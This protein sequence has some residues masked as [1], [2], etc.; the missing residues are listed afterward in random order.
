MGECVKA[1]FR[2]TMQC[3]ALVWGLLAFAATP[4]ESTRTAAPALADLTPVVRI[5]EIRRTSGPTRW[6]FR[7]REGG[8]EALS[9][10]GTSP[11]A[12]VPDAGTVADYKELEGS[13][14]QTA[15][16]V[17]MS[18]EE[19]GKKDNFYALMHDVERRFGH[20]YG[21]ARFTFPAVPAQNPWGRTQGQ[22]ESVDTSSFLLSQ[23]TSISELSGLLGAEDVTQRRAAAKALALI[24]AAESIPPLMKALA[25]TDALVAGTARQSLAARRDLSIRALRADPA[26]KETAGSPHHELLLQLEYEAAVAANTAAAYATFLARYPGTDYDKEMRYRWLQAKGDAAGLKRLTDSFAGGGKVLDISDAIDAGLVKVALGGRNIREV[27]LA[28]RR[29]ANHPITVR[30]PFGSYLVSSDPGAQNMVTTQ[31]LVVDLI[32]HSSPHSV[33]I[34]AACANL[35]KAVPGNQVSFTLQRQS[36]HAELKGVIAALL[37]AKAPYEVQ[38][39]AIWLITDNASYSEL[40]TLKTMVLPVGSTRRVP[41]GRTIGADHVIRAL[42]IV[43]SSGVNVHALAIWRDRDEMSKES[44]D[45]AL[46]RWLLAQP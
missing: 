22:G 39:A 13:E 8:Y 38:Q 7:S 27:H 46:K 16:I 20:R 40:G 19:A 3:M 9:F 18:V 43:A 15:V 21:T 28:L 31:E 10:K 5:L 6:I 45:A 34:S 24:A 1:G 17:L 35:P 30:I 44:R 41:T 23:I 4:A 14:P 32:S 26:A 29:T 2:S 25:D 42:Q 12:E 37:N 33:S 11:L 36:P